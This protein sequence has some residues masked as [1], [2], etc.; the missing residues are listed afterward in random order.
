MAEK[1]AFDLLVEFAREQ[2]LVDEGGEV[3]IKD[4]RLLDTFYEENDPHHNTLTE[5]E[6][7]IFNELSPQY[8][9]CSRSFET[10]NGTEYLVLVGH[11]SGMPPADPKNQE[12]FVV[13][14]GGSND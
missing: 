3:N 4:D 12:I 2:G 11:T 1:K 10:E 8:I 13:R 6:W 9:N 14:K 5:E 7:K